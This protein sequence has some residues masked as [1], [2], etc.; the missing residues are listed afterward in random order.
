M[1]AVS[2]SRSQSIYDD[3]KRLE[4]TNSRLRWKNFVMAALEQGLADGLNQA[5]LSD[6]Q[7]SSVREALASTLQAATTGI[8]NDRKLPKAVVAGSRSYRHASRP[9]RAQA[10]TQLRHRTTARV[11]TTQLDRPRRSASRRA[12]SRS[13]YRSPEPNDS[14]WK[15]PQVRSSDLFAHPPLHPGGES[16]PAVGDGDRFDDDLGTVGERYVVDEIGP[17]CFRDRVSHQPIGELRTALWPLRAS[18]R[19]LLARRLI[20]TRSAV[21]APDLSRPSVETSAA[22][23]I[24]CRTSRTV[25]SESP[26]LRAISRFDSSGKASIKSDAWSRA[27]REVSGRVLP[28]APTRCAWSFVATAVRRVA[29]VWATTRRYLR[30]PDRKALAWLTGSDWRPISVRPG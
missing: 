14:I 16:A 27:I 17:R 5:G 29:T 1:R 24:S 6:A 20:G 23:S 3:L 11:W 28:S 7:Q 12:R 18:D 26:T 13:W 4:K 21:D 8:E 25:A 19:A 22:R 9:H 30:S 2:I 10:E 15:R